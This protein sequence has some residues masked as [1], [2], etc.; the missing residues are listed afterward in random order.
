MKDNGYKIFKELENF[1]GKKGKEY[2]KLLFEKS[3]LK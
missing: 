3:E 2:V 1:A